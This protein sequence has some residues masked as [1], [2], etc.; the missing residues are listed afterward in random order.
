MVASEVVEGQCHQ[1]SGFSDPDSTCLYQHM[2]NFFYRLEVF[3]PA[4]DLEGYVSKGFVIWK[5]QVWSPDK[6]LFLMEVSESIAFAF[7][8]PLNGI[9]LFYIL[10]CMC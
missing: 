1:S 4:N 3:V 9:F 5:E 2:V 8:N 10:L 7:K 6:I